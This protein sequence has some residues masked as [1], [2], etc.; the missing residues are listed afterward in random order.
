[1]VTHVRS[2][3]GE[4]GYRHQLDRARRFLERVQD[5]SHAEWSTANEVEFQDL[6][7]SFFL[8]CWHVKDWVRHDP[9]VTSNQKMAVDDL[10]RQSAVLMACRD[11]CNGT[12]RLGARSGAKQKPI[13]ADYVLGFTVA[14][15]CVI[16]G[17]QGQ[18]NS[19][20][21]LAQLCIGEWERILESQG[22][23][24]ARMS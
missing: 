17:A 11:L 18:E 14:M 20:I 1:M 6:M 8:H 16:E 3:F 21:E 22:L 13:E 5:L 12:K 24:T 10:A 23:A 4:A 9:C 15:D 7:E 2:K 19:G